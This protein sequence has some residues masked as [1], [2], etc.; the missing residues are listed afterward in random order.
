MT[1]NHVARRYYPRCGAPQTTE[2]DVTPDLMFMKANGIDATNGSIRTC[3][4]S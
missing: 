2:P 3:S 4:R 1:D